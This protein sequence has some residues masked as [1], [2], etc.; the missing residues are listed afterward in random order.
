MEKTLWVK[1]RALENEELSSD[2]QH[3]QT[4]SGIAVGQGGI[5]GGRVEIGRIC[6]LT[7]LPA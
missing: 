2:S 4:E 3:P 6:E 1:A 5:V 7:G